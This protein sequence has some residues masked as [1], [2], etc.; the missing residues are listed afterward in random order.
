MIFVL[1]YHRC[2]LLVVNYIIY[3][4]LVLLC[5]V[6]SVRDYQYWQDFANNFN[7]KTIVTRKKLWETDLNQSFTLNIKEINS[8]VKF[9]YAPWWL[10]YCN[11]KWKCGGLK[12]QFCV[13]VD[14]FKASEIHL[15]IITDESVVTGGD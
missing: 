5:H 2:K 1:M 13:Q 11:V 14:P 8:G 9:N 10:I 7:K 4:S 15:P 3:F 6:G 12:F